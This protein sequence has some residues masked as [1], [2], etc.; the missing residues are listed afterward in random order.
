VKLDRQTCYRALRSRDRRFDGLFYV[1]VKTTGIYCRPICPARPV[2]RDRCDFFERP[3]EAE[4]AGF[5]ACFRCRPELAP[6]LSSVDSIPRL[7][8]S[9]VARI[10]AGF[11]NEHS[12]D[13]L[14]A[15]LNVSG[16]HLRRAMETEI[17]VSPVELAQTRRLALA[18]QLLQDTALPLAE[19]AFAAGFASV[20]RFNALFRERFGRSPREVRRQAG[21]EDPAAGLLLR[22]DFRPP[23]DWDGL[24]AFLSARATPRVER[25]V[26]RRYE[27]TVALGDRTGWLTVEP[28]DDRPALGARVS[29]SLAPRLMEV[30]A[31]LRALFDL[32]AQ[33]ALIAEHLAADARLRVSVHRHP[34]LRVP[35]AFDPFEMAVRAVL[36]QQVSVA[37]ATTLSGR[38]AERLGEP[39]RGELAGL[40]RTFPTAAALAKASVDAIQAAGLTRARARTLA[41]L[42]AAVAE[43]RIDFGG[44]AEPAVTIQALQ[45]VPGIGPWT[46]QYIA[47]R[48]LRWPD[49]Y[50]ANDLGLLK[51]LG[52]NARDAT[53][54][55]ERWRP[56]RSYAVMH[57]WRSL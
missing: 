4:K 47:M 53:V 37:G 39:I 33:P 49:A 21:A 22:L 43:G 6:G 32:D 3:A 54:R 10:E 30:A 41:S 40:D 35:G 45:A 11:M 16:R 9:A 31:R 57:L 55:A 14:A 28:Q 5:R 46:A 50:P 25:V 12:L 18:K 51:A 2:R 26:G 1:G 29:L 56:W 24:V 8:A 7:V 36:G 17:G 48:A 23:L 52:A 27:R 38:I 13:D 15:S 34:G 42:S 20:R 44:R 19:L